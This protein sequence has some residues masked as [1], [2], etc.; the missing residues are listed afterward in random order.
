M[1]LCGSS[2]LIEPTREVWNEKT[3]KEVVNNKSPHIH[4]FTKKIFYIGHYLYSYI[5]MMSI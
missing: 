5:G 4:L 3:E 1:V 2:S